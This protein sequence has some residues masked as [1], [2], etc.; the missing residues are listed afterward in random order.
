MS[1]LLKNGKVAVGGQTDPV[2]KFI[3]PTILVDVQPTDPIMQEEI[4]GPIIPIIN[5]ENAAQAIQFINNRYVLCQNLS[6]I[7]VPV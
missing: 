6:I 2:E 1:N 5:V 3:A 7:V 4:F